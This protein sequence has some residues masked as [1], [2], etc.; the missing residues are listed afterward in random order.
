MNHTD[1]QLKQALEKML[2]EKLIFLERDHTLYWKAVF[3]SKTNWTGNAV[4]DTEMLAVCQMIE[5][6][7]NY[8]SQA[9]YTWQL[10]SLNDKFFSCVDS[11]NESDDW[12]E[13]FK[14]THANWQQR[15]IA[16]A[17]VL[18]VTIV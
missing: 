6:E 5:D 4:L 16:L 13:I 3:G 8:E 1:I 2:P 11:S 7:L 15:T 18:G 12:N 14:Y 9:A 17:K 10:Y